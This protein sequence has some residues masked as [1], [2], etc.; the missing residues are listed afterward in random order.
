MYK[1]FNHVYCVL[2]R[3]TVRFCCYVIFFFLYI[4]AFSH[5]SSLEYST[6]NENRC[7]DGEF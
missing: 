4:C 7:S 1:H 6:E 2:V 5:K 3:P